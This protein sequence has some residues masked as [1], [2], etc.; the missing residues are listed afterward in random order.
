MTEIKEEKVLSIE[1]VRKITG[2]ASKKAKESLSEA[3]KKMR[4][5]S[6]DL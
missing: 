6:V 3:V 4:E 1:E 2:R 5:E